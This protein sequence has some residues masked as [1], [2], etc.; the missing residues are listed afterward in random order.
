V[1]V[2]LACVYCLFAAG[3]VF[4]FAAI[5]PVLIAEG[6]YR[7]LCSKQ[8]LDDDVRVCYAQEL[9]FAAQARRRKAP[10]TNW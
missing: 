10:L 6:V 1:Q 9:R 2:F 4:G 3:V 5:K 8:E 7:N